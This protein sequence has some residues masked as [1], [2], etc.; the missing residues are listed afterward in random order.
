[1]TLLVGH[2]Q[3]FEHG[4]LTANGVA[5]FRLSHVSR[6]RKLLIF[7]WLD[8]VSPRVKASIDSK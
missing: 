1:M 2:N 3:T 5:A 7:A 6:L 4:N 8:D